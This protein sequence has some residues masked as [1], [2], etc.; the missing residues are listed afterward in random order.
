[1]K[2]QINYKQITMKGFTL[3]ELIIYMGM[4]MI[5]L[6]V[7][8]QIFTSL[9]DLRLESEASSGVEQDGR[10][11]LSRMIYDIHRATS[12]TTPATLGQS[13]NTLSLV[14]GGTTY[15]YALQG[16]NLTLA[17][18]SAQIVNSF[19]NNI[20]NLT[21]RR[22]GNDTGKHTVQVTYTVT[23]KTQRAAGPETKTV[24]TSVGL[25]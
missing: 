18:S 12:I 5:I 19:D 10:F 25:R 3:V 9:L 16:S 11:I 2:K 1:M 4:M 23:S 17:T 21:F 24:R 13:T 6:V 8:T 20:S 15:T 14:I 22:L 7:L